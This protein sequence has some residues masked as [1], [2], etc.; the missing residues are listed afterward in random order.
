M[1]H[2]IIEND[3]VFRNASKGDYLRFIADSGDLIADVELN[4]QILEKYDDKIE[5]INLQ[6]EKVKIDRIRRFE[7]GNWYINTSNDFTQNPK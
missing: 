7:T 3:S 6:N 2:K 5:Y 1:W 4:Y